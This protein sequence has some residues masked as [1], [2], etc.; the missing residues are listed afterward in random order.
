MGNYLVYKHILPNNKIY[1]GI[2]CNKAETRWNKGL[3]Y[4]KQD[5]FYKA[6]LKYGWDNIKHEVLYTNLTKDEAEDIEIKL[7]KKYKSNIREFGYNI[8]NGGNTKGTHTEETKKKISDSH[9]GKLNPMYGVKSPMTGKKHTEETKQKIR[10]SRIGKQGSFLGKK[11]TK[12]AK[13]KMSKAKKDS[14]FKPYIYGRGHTEETKLKL[15]KIKCKRVRCI[16]TGEIFESLTEA[17]EKYNTT[18][19]NIGNCCRGKYLT[20][21]KDPIT[22]EKLSWEFI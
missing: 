16:N 14:N 7:I 19:Q 12:E 20:A 13:E 17:S 11:H 4:K 1:I 10:E 18:R 6:I 21:S 3:G 8:A 2:T 5:Y 9:K 22:K 15:S